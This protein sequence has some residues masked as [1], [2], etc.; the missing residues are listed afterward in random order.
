MHCC[1]ETS[2]PLSNQIIT[3]VCLSDRPQTANN[4]FCPEHV[5][6]ESVL[7]YGGTSTVFHEPSTRSY[8]SRSFFS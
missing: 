2:F 7:L 3:T 5:K 4:T 8:L 1:I 6:R